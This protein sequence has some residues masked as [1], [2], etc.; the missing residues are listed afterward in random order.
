MPVIRTSEERFENLP[1]F[2]FEPRYLEL[3]GM[4][5]HY[6][7]EG[8]GEVIL[9]VH[10]E[11]S[12]CFL[13]R[14]M[15]PVLGGRHRVVAFDFIGFGRSDKYTEKSEYTYKLHRD[16]MAGFIEALDLTGITLVVQDWGGLIGLR[17]AG[18]MAER[19]SRLVIMN[20][21]LPTG[22][23]K[24]TEGFMRWRNFVEKTEDLPVGMI[25]QGATVTDLSPEVVAAYE[26][27]FPGPEYK[28]GAQAWP[29]MVPVRPD[30]EAAP[31]LRQARQDLQE[32]TKPALVMFSDKDPVTAGGDKFFK[33]HIPGAKGQPHATIKDAGHF[34]QEDKGPEIANRILEFM[35][36]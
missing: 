5:I 29:L 13:Y 14:K 1:E 33:E 17:V 36:G 34:L 20:T 10:G 27:P 7:D 25:I 19:F 22:E 16:T 4:R 30:M 24:M 32:W 6:L 12:W 31:E 21:G 26:A 35:A 18:M 9:C 2:P 15:I 28:A 11:P 3:G 23:Q 8:R